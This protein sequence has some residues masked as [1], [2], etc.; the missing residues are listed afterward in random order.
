MNRKMFLFLST[1]L[2]ATS[3][4]VSIP[5]HA[6]ETT[7]AP[8]SINIAEEQVDASK[9]ED[10]TVKA[11]AP[12]SVTASSYDPRKNNMVTS[13]KNQNPYGLCMLYSGIAAAESNLIRQGLE[14]NTIDLSEIF[15]SYAVYAQSNDKTRNFSK[16][17]CSFPGLTGFKYGDER[18]IHFALESKYPFPYEVVNGKKQNSIPENYCIDNNGLE[19]YK[20]KIGR[21]YNMER[22]NQSTDSIK[23]LKQLI[24]N[25]GGVTA[26]YYNNENYYSKSYSYYFD[27][28][29]SYY[30]P[31]DDDGTNH[32]IEIVG[33]DDNYATSNFLVAPPVNG[34][35][36]VKNSWGYRGDGTVTGNGSGYF[37]LSY[38]DA[39]IN[40]VCAI[41]LIPKDVIPYKTKAYNMEIGSTINLLND[42]TDAQ[43]AEAKSI[44]SQKELDFYMA[45]TPKDFGDFNYSSTIGKKGTGITDNYKN[46]IMW[47][48]FNIHSKSKK[49]ETNFES[50]NTYEVYE[51]EFHGM[52][53]EITTT[54]DGVTIPTK[55]LEYSSDN[56]DVVSLDKEYNPTLDYDNKDFDI[57]KYGTA[58]ITVS[59]S[60]PIITEGET[61]TTSFTITL[62]KKPDPYA[63]M[64]TPEGNPTPVTPPSTPSTTQA[65]AG[66]TTQAPAKAKAPVVWVFPKNEKDTGKKAKRV[67]KGK[68]VYEVKGKVAVVKY[69]DLAKKDTI[70]ILDT[71]KINGKKYKVTKIAKNAFSMVNTTKIIIKSKNIKTIG[72]NAF[73]VMNK[74]KLKI[75]V[76]KGKKEAYY[77]LIKKSTKGLS[78]K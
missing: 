10:I 17:P 38:Y 75:T 12:T 77:K 13:V 7:E 32:Q 21:A 61:L 57:N 37:W 54:L 14:N 73:N 25:Y 70:T 1:L 69:L 71:V 46:A 36:L 16:N 35:W 60:D 47:W 51:D 52:L 64:P 41:N 11:S 2:L 72:K 40:Y 62:K 78:I 8:V 28:D 20:Y 4:V 67:V 63:V 74:K 15:S 29:N 44:L 23:E 30:Y 5:V 53:K 9:I 76:P 59:Y 42:L 6:E 45:Y 27:G 43:L 49:L 26:S 24:V 68:V 34:A 55:M 19:D 31:Y 18:Y 56:E 66:T 50:E 65:G 48:I 39:S 58:K 3:L 33:W 22:Y